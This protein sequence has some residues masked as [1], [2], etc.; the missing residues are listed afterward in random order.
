MKKKSNFRK[1]VAKPIPTGALSWHTAG[2]QEPAP[3]CRPGQACVQAAAGSRFGVCRNCRH[4][5][6]VSSPMRDIGWVETRSITSR[7]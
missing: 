3:R 7:R 5:R 2:R 4:S 1:R 6:G